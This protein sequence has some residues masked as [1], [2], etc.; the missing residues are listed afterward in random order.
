MPSGGY[1]ANA[2][3]PK[4]SA[5]EKALEGNPGKRPIEVVDFSDADEI[6]ATPPKWMTD[7]RAK[8][9]YTF[10]YEWLKKIGCTKGILPS[11]LEEYAICKSRWHECEN[12]IERVGMVMK[13]NQGKIISSPYLEHAR[14]YLK[15]SNE[16][17]SKIYQVVRETKLKEW[18]NANPND[19][20][21]EKLLGGRP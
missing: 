12:Q 14:N 6:P 21:M 4:K 11:H 17:W 19:D 18:D 15:Q 2:G 3:R 1:R 9:I 20:V 8:E 16:V 5:T 10:V 13:D 7:T